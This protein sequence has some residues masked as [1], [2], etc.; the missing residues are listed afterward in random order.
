MFGSLAIVTNNTTTVFQT[1]S[2]PTGPALES[3]LDRLLSVDAPSPHK[4]ET[5]SQRLMQPI[6]IGVANSTAGWLRREQAGVSGRGSIA[7]ILWSKLEHLYAFT[8]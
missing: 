1:L 8:L 6:D 3:I 7:P 4:S 5:G 2:L